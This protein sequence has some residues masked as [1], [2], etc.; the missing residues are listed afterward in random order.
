[1]GIIGNIITGIAG[2]KTQE[3]ANR[4]QRQNI[5]AQN[6][7]N[8]N[9]AKYQYS[10]DLDMWNRANQYNTPESQMKRYQQAG[11]NPN[12]IYGQGS[13]G[14]SPNS[15][16]HFQAPQ[17]RYD[18]PAPLNPIMMLQQYQDMRIK[19]AQIDLLKSQRRVTDFN[20]T[21]KGVEA[22]YSRDLT[23]QKFQTGFNNLEIQMYKRI[24]SQEEFESLFTQKDDG[25]WYSKNPDLFRR[26]AESKL[27][28]PES[29]LARTNAEVARINTENDIKQKE[30]EF[31]NSGGKYFSPIINFLRMFR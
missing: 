1:M 18:N 22:D 23:E 16:P 9:L 14:N 31:L 26:S 4:Q 21:I 19:S 29:T 11:L 6:Q 8:M 28:Q 2:Y 20:A 12:L 13:S 17:M 15:L 27:G 24:M 25:K 3:L 7:G 30:L 5:I 10:Q